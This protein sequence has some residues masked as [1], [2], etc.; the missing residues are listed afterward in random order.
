[1][2]SKPPPIARWSKPG[3]LSK[4]KPESFGI[5]HKAD[6]NLPINL[7]VGDAK[8]RWEDGVW[9]NLNFD[10]QPTNA[11]PSTSEIVELQKENAQLRVECE[12]LL[13]MLTVSEMKKAK[14]QE[15]LSDLKV[16][17]ANLVELAEKQSEN[18]S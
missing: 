17:I 11:N 18:N 9:K 8:L 16:R 5:Y 2:Q 6:G 3:F 12:I 15:T 1:M 14:A 4:K 13:H 10:Q 7:D